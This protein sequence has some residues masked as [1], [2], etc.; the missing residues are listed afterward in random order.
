MALPKI[1]VTVSTDEHHDRTSELKL[2]EAYFASIRLAGGEPVVFPMDTP[3]DKVPEIA[4][5]FQGILLTGGGDIDPAIFNGEPHPNVYGI[6]P[7]R[8]LLEIALVNYCASN[9]LPL[10]G[11][12]R[13]LQVI[14]V[15]LGGTLYTDIT[16]Q[17]TGALRHS[18]FPAYP[19]D[20]LAH[21][22]HLTVSTRLTAIT[23]Q[24]QIMV[25]SMH[26][27]GIKNLAPDLTLSAIAP[28]GL[29]EGIEFMFHPFLLG[30]QWHPECL[31]NSPSDL[32][33]FSA[34]VRSGTPEE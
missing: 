16:D 15:A 11:I 20:Y 3:V 22:I 25:N 1:G 28:D 21:S 19:R 26:H 8:D 34:F 17:L 24:N 2:K 7:Q 13:G 30:V 5:T 9:N 31:P 18:C 6:D 23:G 10:L 27:Q 32:A 4:A 33:I 29:A 12:C 14:N